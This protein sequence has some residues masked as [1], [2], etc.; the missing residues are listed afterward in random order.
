M[1]Q[2]FIVSLVENFVEFKK[3][4]DQLFYSKFISNYWSFA[5]LLLMWRWIDRK[6]LSFAWNYWVGVIMR[7]IGRNLILILCIRWVL[8]KFFLI[9]LVLI[10]FFRLLLVGLYNRYLKSDFFYWYPI[11]IYLLFFDLFFGNHFF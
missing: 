9:Y 2:H 5:V 8:G 3:E 10:I 7:Q 4:K 1:K 6:C 11:V